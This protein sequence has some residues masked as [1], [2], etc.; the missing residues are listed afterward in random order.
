MDADGGRSLNA[1]ADIGAMISE[2]NR[3]DAFSRTNFSSR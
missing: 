3:H 2:I 1:Q